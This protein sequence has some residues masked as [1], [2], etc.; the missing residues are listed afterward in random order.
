[1]AVQARVVQQRDA[2]G[3]GG[4]TDVWVVVVEAGGDG[5]EEQWP[6]LASPDE[7]RVVLGREAKVAHRCLGLVSSAAVATTSKPMKAK[8]TM[9]A[10]VK[11]PM[12][13]KLVGS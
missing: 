4:F 7:R 11:M 6:D 5:G 10:A 13:P 9:E 3:E 1:M 12:T 8:K 2:G